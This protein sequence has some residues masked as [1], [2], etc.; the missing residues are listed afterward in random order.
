MSASSDLAVIGNG[1]ML[2]KLER[3]VREGKLSHAYILDGPSGSGRHTIAKWLCAAIAC[4]NRPNQGNRY[5]DEDQFSMFDAFDPLPSRTVDPTAP[6][7]CGI[8]PACRKL[9][10]GNCPDVRFIGRDGKASIGVD[11]IRFLKQDVLLAPNDLDTKIY[12][13][14]DA[15]TM[16]AQ[17]QNALLLT[18]EEPPSYV[19][20]LLLCNGADGL[21]ET[22][23]SRA[24]VLK[25]E[26]ISDED[27]R[28]YLRVNKRLSVSNEELDTVIMASDGRIGRALE[29]TDAKSV[30]AIMKLRAAVDGF[31]D[32]CVTHNAASVLG[33]IAAFGNK[34]D[35]VMDILSTL[36]LALRDL[37]ALKN[38]DSVT[39][40]YYIDR[41]L[42]FELSSRL[43]TRAMLRIYDAVGR[44]KDGLDRNGNIR[45]TLTGMCLE[46]GLL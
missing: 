34:R 12:I 46:C 13:I 14:E 21:L 6:L 26:P 40:K 36:T 31:I 11:S 43:S 33:A 1:A 9:L 17:A 8:C 30:K 20:F 18:L 45:L 44:A 41:E 23:R 3:D 10:D 28:S 38:T 15:E 39:L 29:L 42:A 25:T 7:P 16:T 19:L 37:L 22:I 24:P 2:D 35:G 4:E 32:G 27:I 5:E